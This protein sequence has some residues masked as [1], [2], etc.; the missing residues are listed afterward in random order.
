MI[1]YFSLL[2]RTGL[3]LSYT[4]WGNWEMYSSSKRTPESKPVCSDG[5]AVCPSAPP[6]SPSFPHLT[7]LLPLGTYCLVVVWHSRLH[8]E[9]WWPPCAGL[10]TATWGAWWQGEAGK[11]GP[12]RKGVWP[13]DQ[14]FSEVYI[15]EYLPEPFKSPFCRRHIYEALKTPSLPPFLGKPLLTRRS[16]QLPHQVSGNG[17]LSSGLL[18]CAL[19]LVSRDFPLA[20]YVPACAVAV[21][22]E[23][24]W[25]A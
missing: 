17:W 11:G 21:S 25:K 2:R 16:S 1:S 14:L 15:N 7:V 6:H 8:L 13:G 20:H 9:E 23:V 5:W 4:C 24:L 19:F 22:V 10:P 3:S 18:L 12:E